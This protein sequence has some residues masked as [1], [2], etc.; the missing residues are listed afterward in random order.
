MGYEA[1]TNARDARLRNIDSSMR[2]LEEGRQAV[3]SRNVGNALG[4][5]D[6]NAAARAAYQGGDVGT[7]LTIQ[8]AGRT[9][10][11]ETR[12]RQKSALA[13]AAAGL[14]QMP[15]ANRAQ[16]FQ[17]V[18]APRLRQEGVPDEW[19]GQITPEVL[20]DAQLRGFVAAIGGEAPAAPSGY[21][22]T[23]DGR[24]EYVPGGP[25]DPANRPPTFVPGFGFVDPMLLRQYMGGQGQAPAAPAAPPEYVDQLPPG[26]R[27]RPNQAPSARPAAG[28][29]ERS[30]PVSVSFRSSAD[31]QADIQRTVPGVRV[32]SGRRSPEEQRR[33]IAQWEAGGRRGVRPSDT[34]FHLQDRA[35][36]LIP[37][38]GMSMAELADKMRRRGYRVLNEGDHVHVS[39]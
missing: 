39:W 14:L 10:E 3:V 4:S 21:R 13:A 26:V 35:R 20:T 32:T 31:A 25:A 19:I 7:G 5:G 29:A 36:D 17:G 28:G 6:F 27:P 18:L 34:S 23:A 24:Q 30:Q 11:R 16:V 15:E 1:F 9:Q 37:P 8:N 33:L 38:P 22:W 12:E 2:A